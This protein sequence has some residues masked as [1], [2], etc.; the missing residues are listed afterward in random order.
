MIKYVKIKGISCDEC[1][2][3][4]KKALLENKKIT[5]VKI[6]KNVATIECQKN[7]KNNEIIKIITDLDYFTKEEY[8]S[9]F[10]PETNKKEFFLIAIIILG[11]LFLLNKVFGYN[12]F[13]VIPKIDSSITYSM[14]FITGFFTSIHCL[15]MCG[16]LNL[17]AIYNDKKDFSKP[18]FYNLGRLI[19]YTLLGGIVGFLGKTIAFNE[20]I[21]GVVIIISSILMFLMALKILGFIN[22]KFICFGRQKFSIS[23]AFVIGL[24]NGLMPCGPLQAMQV[25]ALSTQSFWAGAL[26]MF[27]F[28][29][30]TIPLMLSFGLLFN[31]LKGKWKVL[32]NEISAVLILILSIIMLNRGLLFLNIDFF[33]TSDY[34]NYVAAVMQN[35]VQVVNFS[36]KYSS[37]EDILVQKN[38]PVRII[39]NVE[40]KYL[41][42]CNNEILIPDFNI[43]EKLHVG[44]NIIEFT[45]NEVGEYS[46]TCYMRMIKNNIKVIDNKNFFKESK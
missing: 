32:I 13:N 6:T 31:I 44:E 7:L 29:L 15:S 24:L 8:I 38:I 27:L 1:R 26:A 17:L 4:I 42:E 46:Y 34:D 10:K 14:L 28:C 33:K 19:S 39:I 16:S 41:T 25:Y 3:K 36:L 2:K 18:I 35:D 20:T 12:I 22:F 37:Y 21:S 23:N 45:P 43:D 30:G 11:I 9:T 40:E 5:K